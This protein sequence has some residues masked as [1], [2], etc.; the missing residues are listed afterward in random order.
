MFIEGNQGP[1]RLRREPLHQNRIGRP[2]ACEDLVRREPVD[3]G[4]LAGL[5]RHL[6]ARLAFGTPSHQRLGLGEKVGEEHAVMIAK[7]AIDAGGGDEIGG[8]DVRALMNE[9]IEGVL[10]V[11]ARFAED[12]RAGRAGNRHSIDPPALAV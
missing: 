4:R 6:F 11:R 1:E 12:D 7:L 9:L 3:I 2:V 5:A 8:D 10:A